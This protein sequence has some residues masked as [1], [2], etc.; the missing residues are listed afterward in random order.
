MHET[1]MEYKTTNVIINETSRIQIGLGRTIEWNPI[2]RT[3]LSER[4]LVP[5]AFHPAPP[6]VV[7]T[8]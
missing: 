5:V 4:I 3:S 2:A 6:N 7:K 1:Q 8:P